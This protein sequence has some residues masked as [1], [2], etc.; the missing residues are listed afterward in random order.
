MVAWKDITEQEIDDYFLVDVNLLKVTRENPW[1]EITIPC[2]FK[3]TGHLP[4]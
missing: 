1:G 2:W 4:I 3:N